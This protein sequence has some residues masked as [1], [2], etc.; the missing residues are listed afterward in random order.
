MIGD[1]S[2][3]G[4]DMCIGSGLWYNNTKTLRTK[5]RKCAQRKEVE[6]LRNIW[7]AP[8]NR[9]HQTIQRN[10]MFFENDARL[11]QYSRAFRDR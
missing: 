7:T 8:H 6:K 4:Y 10:K 1:R 11:L 5:F 2:M 9:D 3:I